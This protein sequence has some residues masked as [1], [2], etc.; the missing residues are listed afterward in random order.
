[1]V[2]SWWRHQMETFS[3][4]LAICAGNSPVTG[5]FPTQRPVARSLDVFFDMHLNKRLSKQSW[6]WWFETPSLPLWRH[7]NVMYQMRCSAMSFMVASTIL[8]QTYDRKQEHETCPWYLGCTIWS[9]YNRELHIYTHIQMIM[10]C[11][12]YI[13]T[14]DCGTTVHSGRRDKWRNEHPEYNMRQL[15]L[16]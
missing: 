5:K 9:L 14:S 1:M 7:S 3:A 12:M 13:I 11:E 6:G 16:V 15:R 2:Y 10:A 4:L 8:G